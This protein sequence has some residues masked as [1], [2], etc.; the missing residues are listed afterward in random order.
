[1]T[2]THARMIHATQIKEDVSMSPEIVLA[3]MTAG[4]STGAS[5]QRD[6][7]SDSV[8]EQATKAKTSARAVSAESGRKSA[9]MPG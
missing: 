6:D 5:P 3:E 1:M 4:E 9:T 8:A 2:A 7:V